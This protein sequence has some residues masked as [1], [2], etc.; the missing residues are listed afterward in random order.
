[1]KR[2]KH[3]NSL[4]V[5][6]TTCMFVTT[7]S[8]ATLSMVA[9][10]YK[11]RVAE[12]KRVEN[13]YASDSGLDVAYVIMGKTFDAAAKYGYHEVEL[14]KKED[15]ARDAIS[16]NNITYRNLKTDIRNNQR[17]IEYLKN[18]TPMTNDIRKTIAKDNDK[19]KQDND[20]INILINNEFKRTFKNFIDGVNVEGVENGRDIPYYIGH[21][22]YVNEVVYNDQNNRAA[23]TFNTVQV[24]YPEN[25]SPNLWIPQNGIQNPDGIIESENGLNFNNDN[26]TIT[27]KSRFKTQNQ[28]NTSVIGENLRIVQATYEIK[29]P[30][31]EDIFY[32]QMS[33]EL[34]N[35]LALKDRALTIGKDM[36]VNNVNKLEMNGD[37]FINGNSD[38]ISSDRVYGKY[39]GGITLNDSD[40][41]SFNNNVITRGTFNIRNDVGNINNP[42]KISG[43]LYARNIY[44]GTQN[45]ENY[46]DRAYL[47]A[48]KVVIDNDLA[49]KA[50]NT[51]VMINDFYGINDM[52]NFYDDNKGN[53]INNYN[54]NPNDKA[55]A[56]SSIIINDTGLEGKGS[57]VSITDSAYIMGTAHIATARDY[58]T[59]ESTAI[60]GNYEAYSIPLDSSEKLIY[61]S[62]LQLLD[63]PNVFKKAEHFVKYWKDKEVDT[64]GIYL[65]EGNIHSVGAVVY[66]HKDAQS[67]N[68]VVE[69]TKPNYINDLEKKYTGDITVKR[70][71]FASKVYKFGQEAITDNEKEEMLNI[72]NSLGTGELQVNN[73]MNL[74]ETTIGTDYKLNDQINNNGEKAIF[75]WDSRNT[76]VIQGAHS[77]KDYDPN[78]YTVIDV[79]NNKE[80][81]AVIATAGDVIIDGDVTFTGSIIADGNLNIIGNA[82]NVSINYDKDVVD[83]IQAQNYDLFFNVFGVNMLLDTSQVQQTNQ[84]VDTS[85]SY[86]LKKFLQSNKWKIIK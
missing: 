57:S 82:A 4:I 47:S 27:V 74:S 77:S 51:H 41:I 16:E 14:L 24:K 22:S 86:D 10:N 38:N 8:A 83:R 52:N 9:G 25:T 42:A 80:I 66:K 15:E 56:S 26:Y 21:G 46:T 36:N 67:P 81:S 72:Y 33:G 40:N 69:I 48:N 64:G 31:Y 63:E 84:S 13:L 1:M 85:I 58:Q 44:A 53:R 3:G 71:E 7:V 73:L 12:S 32:K 55:R 11:A 18:T 5:V 61:D 19:I 70:I 76:I 54:S 60:K 39:F 75:N 45:G 49:I 29:V 50:T 2:K 62:P 20:E 68:D 43:D 35:Y 28:G 30:N 78:T 17:E 79:S 37:I 34:H 23:F 6:I 65:P 59:G